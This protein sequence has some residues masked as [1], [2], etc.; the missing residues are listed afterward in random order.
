VL[1]QAFFLGNLDLPQCAPVSLV[2]DG[3]QVAVG[4]FV[5]CRKP[6]IMGTL[7]FLDDNFFDGECVQW[8]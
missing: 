7:A 1:R 8:G 5:S 4:N 2:L 6:R 3:S